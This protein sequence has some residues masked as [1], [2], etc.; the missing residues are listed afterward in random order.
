MQVIGVVLVITRNLATA[1]QPPISKATPHQ[2]GPMRGVFSHVG[3]ENFRSEYI[4]CRRARRHIP[5]YKPGTRGFS[6]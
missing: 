6:T 1:N 5:G 2:P 4:A 3:M